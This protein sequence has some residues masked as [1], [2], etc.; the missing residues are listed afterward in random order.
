MR[1]VTNGLIYR[2]RRFARTSTHGRSGHRGSVP[3]S[4]R[5]AAAAV[6]CSSNSAHEEGKALLVP[7]VGAQLGKSFDAFMVSVF[8]AH[9]EHALGNIAAARALAAA[10]REN[11]EAVRGIPEAAFM[12]SR[13]DAELAAPS[14]QP[15]GVAQ[16]EPCLRRRTENSAFRP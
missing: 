9:A 6:L 5:F 11:V 8:L 7:L 2:D 12:L 15:D 3:T 14:E 1:S 16:S 13:L 10:A 4:P